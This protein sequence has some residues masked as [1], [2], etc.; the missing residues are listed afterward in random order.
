[1]ETEKQLW[2]DIVVTSP[3]TDPD[4]SSGSSI[5][6][7]L[8][9]Q[10]ISS[11]DFI[12]GVPMFIVGLSGNILTL[13]NL[14]SS[15]SI[16]STSFRMLMI[17]LSVSDIGVL[18]TGLLRQCSQRLTTWDGLPLW[19]VYQWCCK[20]HVYLPY[21]FE[22]LSSWTLSLV[23]LERALAVICPS[24]AAYLCT[25]SRMLGAWIAILA[26]V[27]SFNTIVIAK[28]GV[29]SNQDPTMM[30]PASTKF[31]IVNETVEV[32]DAYCGIVPSG[33]FFMTSVMPVIFVL[34]GY[35]IPGIVI[36][37]MNV[38][39]RRRLCVGEEERSVPWAASRLNPE[40]RMIFG[41]SV[42]FILTNLLLAVFY[43]CYHYLAGNLKNIIYIIMLGIRSI[44]IAVKFGVAVRDLVAG[45]LR[46]NGRDGWAEGRGRA[47]TPNWYIYS[48]TWELGTPKGL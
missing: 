42:R 9:R 21:V 31:D 32:S 28:V 40:T 48:G 47:T 36:L 27:S 4:N 18:S 41:I 14:L 25:K 13:I 46:R 34:V 8:T 10:W 2:R 17:L 24:K 38:I 39:L 15:R 5:D 22:E 20:G 29:A 45:N 37:M 11:L 12:I 16:R 23:T 35:V 7:L 3:T 6:G 33:D 30:S 1:M 26:L 44:S 43:V 19:N